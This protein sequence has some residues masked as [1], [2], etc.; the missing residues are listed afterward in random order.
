MVIA[1]DN[2]VPW[3]SI[4][5]SLVEAIEKLSVDMESEYFAGLKFETCTLLMQDSWIGADRHTLDKGV[6]G[7]K[8][9]FPSWVYKF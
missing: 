9:S 6:V 5:F 8:N 4:I 1:P 7:S 2:D 3:S